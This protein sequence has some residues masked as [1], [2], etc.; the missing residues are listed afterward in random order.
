MDLAEQEMISLIQAGDQKAFEKAFK[1][2]AKPLHAYGYTLLNNSH[3]AEE[4]IQDLFLKIWEQ[5]E[6][7]QIHTSLKAYLYRSLHND[8]MNHIRHLKVKRNYEDTVNKEGSGQKQYQ[9]IN[10][11][12]VKEIQQKLRTGLSKLPE[13]CRTVFQLSRFEHLTYREIASQLG[14]SIKTVENQMGKAFKI[15]RGELQDYLVLIL[16]LILITTII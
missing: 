6:A 12:E 14:L 8:C 9:P 11:L 5:R 13:A 2:Y 10:R 16:L 4:M 3:I 15:L 7:L 1:T